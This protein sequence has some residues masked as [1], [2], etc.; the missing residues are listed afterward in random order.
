MSERRELRRIELTREEAQ[1]VKDT[2]L[3][4]AIQGG[5]PIPCKCP[6]CSTGLKLRAALTTPS[7]GGEG[8]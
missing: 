5:H 7:K 3:L 8:E 4:G 6:S 2:L 1:S